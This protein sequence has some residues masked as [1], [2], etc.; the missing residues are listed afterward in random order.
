MAKNI[1]ELE[2][3]LLLL[4]LKKE[5]QVKHLKSDFNDFVESMK[6]ANI[7]KRGFNELIG[8]NICC[9][10][11]DVTH[12]RTS[13]KAYSLNGLLQCQTPANAP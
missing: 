13:N 10:V 7:I 3:Q 11:I 8:E 4:E 1:L 9:E 5:E 2:K 12:S 6:P